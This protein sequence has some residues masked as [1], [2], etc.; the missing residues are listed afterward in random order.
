MSKSMRG[1]KNHSKKNFY[2]FF[3]QSI[4]FKKSIFGPW[5][6]VSLPIGHV[7]DTSILKP[8][9]GGHEVFSNSDKVQDPFDVQPGRP[10]LGQMQPERV[11]TIGEYVFKKTYIIDSSFGEIDLQKGHIN[12]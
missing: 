3:R 10:N 7:L 5:P 11:R 6:C 8:V 2:N 12:I 1:F 9:G 4:I